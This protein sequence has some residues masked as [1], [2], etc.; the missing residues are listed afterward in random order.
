VH[1]STDVSSEDP[2]CIMPGLSTPSTG[3]SRKLRTRTK[4]ALTQFWRQYR[5]ELLMWA[6]T[7]EILVSPAADQH[8]R[9][10]ALLAVFL[11]LGVLAAATFMANR[12]IVRLIVIPIAGVWL[13]ARA[14]EE[15]GDPRYV[16]AHLA[17]IAGLALSIST[18][19]AIFDR[20]NSV[21]R[22][23]RSAMAEAFICYLIIAT[24][25][26]QLYWIMSRLIDNPFNQPIQ[27]SQSGALMYFS[28]VTL[29]SVGYGYIAPVNPYV[30]MVAA[31]ESMCGIFYIAVVVA[32]LVSSYRPSQ[33]S[34][35]PPSAATRGRPIQVR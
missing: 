17:P 20:F 6:L 15:F 1:A 11:F 33:G 21:P 14:W 25:F 5:S 29:S 8:P 28:M 10:G 13:A 24:A 3:S 23:P 27:V 7:A 2:S 32:R 4:L 31:L 34:A 30:R 22:T 16:Y 9:A 12:R 35:T 18:L 19:W 26:S